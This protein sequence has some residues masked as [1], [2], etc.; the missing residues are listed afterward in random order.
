MLKAKSENNNDDPIASINKALDALQQAIA[1]AAQQGTF[2][3]LVGTMRQINRRIQENGLAHIPEMKVE[4]LNRLTKTFD[5]CLKKDDFDGMS[6]V[7]NKLLNLWENDYLED[8]D[9]AVHLTP[10]YEKL[11]KKIISALKSSNHSTVQPYLNYFPELCTDC[12]EFLPQDEAVQKAITKKFLTLWNNADYLSLECFN[13]ENF[14]NTIHSAFIREIGYKPI[15]DLVTE[16]FTIIIKEAI[17]SEDDRK[18][19]TVINYFIGTSNFRLESQCDYSKDGD[20]NINFFSSL[21]PSEIIRKA[22]VQLEKRNKYVLFLQECDF[23]ASPQC[24]AMD[25]LDSIKGIFKFSKESKAF[26]ELI[27]KKIIAAADVVLRKER[28][29]AENDSV[30]LSSS[31]FRI[32]APKKKQGL[33][34][35]IEMSAEPCKHTINT[36][37]RYSSIKRCGR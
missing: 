8:N 10:L 1:D 25:F 5:S 11:S 24:F 17:Q 16:C 37:I 26:K 9:L 18:L 35:P 6:Q 13:S 4:D 12:E 34:F 28:Q 29:L 7:I 27:I 3:D 14:G 15:T 22:C 19:K 33:A 21:K 20:S 36:D 32:F 2:Y 23:S 30:E 31:S